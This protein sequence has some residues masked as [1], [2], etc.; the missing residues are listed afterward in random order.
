[1]TNIA[2]LGW[3]SLIWDPR[4]LPIRSAWFEDGPLIPLEFARKS[5]D[6]RI[7]LVKVDDAPAVRSLWAL[8]DTVCLDDAKRRLAER[9][10]VRKENIGKH[11]GSWPHTS[12]PTIS[13]LGEWAVA[14]NIDAAV[15]T[16]LPPK[17]DNDETFPDEDQIIAY[18]GD[19]T[20]PE[21]DEAERYVRQAPRQIDTRYRRRIEAVLGWSPAT[22]EQAEK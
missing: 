12:P 3:G 9:E 5:Q 6:G 1:M 4:E 22:P 2:C 20:G 19:L 15:W 8:M 17:F 18:L 14:R 7:T 13:G 10:G 11:I 21:R 16:A